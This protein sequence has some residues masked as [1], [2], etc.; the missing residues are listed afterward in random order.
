MRHRKL[1]ET[2]VRQ[3]QQVQKME[4]GCGVKHLSRP[5]VHAQKTPVSITRMVV[6]NID[7][8]LGDFFK[9]MK[10]KGF[11][12][13]F[14]ALQLLG[15]YFTKSNASFLLCLRSISSILVQE[16]PYSVRWRWQ[17]L[18]LT[19]EAETIWKLFYFSWQLVQ[20][21]EFRSA[22]QKHPPEPFSWQVAL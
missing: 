1:W 19:A 10:R 3:E 5:G 13:G 2:S 7:W 6:S 11:I 12:F 20:A 9:K 8:Y 16:I 21:H 15:S 22:N 14:R 18:P 4:W 17:V